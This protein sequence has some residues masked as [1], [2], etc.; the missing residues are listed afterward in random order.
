MC[1]PARTRHK[2]P[3]DQ[4]LAQSARAIS[5]LR[6]LHGLSAPLSRWT[7]GRQCRRS[8]RGLTWPS[9][10]PGGTDAVPRPPVVARLLLEE[11]VI[12][13]GSLC[14]VGQRRA[15]VCIVRKNDRV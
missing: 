8:N 7:A 4:P 14:P 5:P 6:R 2:H 13:A 15:L 3:A 1:F 9:P 10:C 11:Q 12:S